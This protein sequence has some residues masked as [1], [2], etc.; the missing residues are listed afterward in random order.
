MPPHGMDEFTVQRAAVWFAQVPGSSPDSG[1]A[2]RSSGAGVSEGAGV[3]KETVT[4]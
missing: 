1:N 4:G 3:P 2:S